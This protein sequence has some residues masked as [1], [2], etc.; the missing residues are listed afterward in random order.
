MLNLAYNVG[1]MLLEGD[2]VDIADIAD[3]GRFMVH[4]FVNSVQAFV[5]KPL[6]FW[7]E[8]LMPIPMYPVKYNNHG[9]CLPNH[10]PVIVTWSNIYWYSYVVLPR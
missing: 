7:E 5:V 3:S 6:W 10:E 9:W 8:Q 1:P 4:T 2:I